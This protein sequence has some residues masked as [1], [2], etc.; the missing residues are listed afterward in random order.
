[1]KISDFFF[2]SWN[3]FIVGILVV[4][5]IMHQFPYSSTPESSMSAIEKIN[6]MRSEKL[7]FS[8][9][10]YKLA[11]IRTEDMLEN[12]Y[13]SHFSPDRKDI[14]HLLPPHVSGYEA[15][16]CVDG[17]VTLTESDAIKY[18]LDSDE[19]RKILLEKGRYAGFYCENGIC[20]FIVTSHEPSGR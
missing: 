4:G 1:M 5:F 3:L 8:L 11:K 14:F 17:A 20:V 16:L 15:I 9:G 12:E 18:F 10:V 2:I 7:I 13:C 19:H 6:E